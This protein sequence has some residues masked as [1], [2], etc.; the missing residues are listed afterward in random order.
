VSSILELLEKLE[1]ACLK[2]DVKNEELISLRL[3]ITQEL[4]SAY[5]EAEKLERAYSQIS[6]QSRAPKNQKMIKRK[7]PQKLKVKLL[8][9]Q[10]YIIT[11]Y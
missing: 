2:L 6:V 11:N 4:Y 5:I 1:D 3:K 7:P 10:L 9:L 8:F